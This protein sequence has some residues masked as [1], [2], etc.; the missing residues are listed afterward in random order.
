MV[1]LNRPHDPNATTA[2][3][4]AW[5]ATHLLSEVFELRGTTN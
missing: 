5:I 2:R 1:E 3:A 4:A